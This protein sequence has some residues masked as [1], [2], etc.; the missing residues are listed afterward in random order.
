MAQA[1]NGDTVRV[2][3]TGSLEDGT[4]F[5]SS[6]GREPLEFTL[7]EGQLIAGFER[8]VLGMTP[9]DS[10]Q[11]TISPEEGYGP[12][13]EEMVIAIGRDKVPEGL[14]LEVDMQVQLQT[15]DGRPAP[16]TVVEISAESVTLDVNHPLAGKS[17][18]FDIDLVEIV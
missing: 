9:G 4:I 5:D 17:L 2:H 12:H 10:V 14:A 16:A 3:Y 8:A 18:V 13:L 15:P 1:S 11:V 6:T 7:G